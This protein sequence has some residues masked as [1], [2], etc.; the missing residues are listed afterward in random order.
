MLIEKVV[1]L[2]VFLMMGSPAIAQTSTVDSLVAIGLQEEAVDL[3]LQQYNRDTS[4]YSLLEELAQIEYNRGNFK[5]AKKHLHH[6]LTIPGDSISAIK[7]LA[8]IYELEENAGR[9]IKYNLLLIQTYPD[10]GVYYRKVAKQ[11]RTAGEP[12][13]ALS[14]YKQA[15]DKNDLDFFTIKGLSELFLD[16]DML[17]QADTILTM[18]IQQ[19]SMNIAF[20]LL[21][22]RTK[23]KLKDYENTCNTL[24]RIRGRYD[25]NNYYSKMMGYSLMQIDSTD[26]AI[27]W[28]EKSLVNEGNPEAAH[29]YLSEA[30]D[31]K[32]EDEIAIH[33]LEKA[34]KAGTSDNLSKYHRNLAK[35]YDDQKNLKKAIPHYEEAY[36]YGKDPRMLFYLARAYDAYFED[37]SVAIRYYERYIKSDDT[38]EEYKSYARDRR[39]YLKEQNHLRNVS[40]N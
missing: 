33:H 12:T 38:V 32:G 13:G 15:Y 24:D 26:M 11:Y 5:T 28:L 16:L 36:K 1:I 23:Y 37:K 27:V 20:N 39:I 21:M 17:D 34:I 9:A 22:A 7:K 29:Y 2:L 19:D 25:F 18:A 8:N 10:N 30:Y 31:I 35:K 40:N 6:I 4:D 14:Y 3:L